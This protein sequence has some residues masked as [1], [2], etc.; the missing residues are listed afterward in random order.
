MAVLH[1]AAAHH[2]F[3]AGRFAIGRGGENLWIEGVNGL[4]QKLGEAVTEGHFDREGQTK[5]STAFRQHFNSLPRD[6][7]CGIVEH[8][9]SAAVTAVT[10]SAFLLCSSSRGYD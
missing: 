8:V 9:H 5:G 1:A 6:A 7:R 3:G 2:R 4:R 10:P